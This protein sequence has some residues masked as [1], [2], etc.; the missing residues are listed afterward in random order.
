MPGCMASPLSLSLTR[1]PALS[2]SLSPSLSL[3]LSLFLM[4]Q[5]GLK[6]CGLSRV[7]ALTDQATAPRRIGLKPRDTAWRGCLTLTLCMTAVLLFVAVWTFCGEKIVSPTY[8][9]GCWIGNEHALW[10]HLNLVFLSIKNIFY[11]CDKIFA[12]YFPLYEKEEGTWKSSLALR[13]F[14]CHE[15]TLNWTFLSLNILWHLQK[16]DSNLTLID[17][18]CLF[19]IQY[20]IH[21]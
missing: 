6:V 15:T 12:C 2:V 5:S 3:S 10:P 7:L 8:V 18:A 17:H 1:S 9:A 16:P 21:R 4:G 11:K 19:S 20:N 13:F 14:L